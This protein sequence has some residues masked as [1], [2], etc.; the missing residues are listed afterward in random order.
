MPAERRGGGFVGPSFEREADRALHR[1]QEWVQC[2]SQECGEF[3]DAVL[4]RQTGSFVGED[5][6]PLAR[7]ER[8]VKAFR[9]DDR[10]GTEWQYAARVGERIRFRKRKDL[11]AA[12]ELEADRLA[13]AAAIPVERAKRV[14]ADRN[15]AHDGRDAD[16]DWHGHLAR[17]A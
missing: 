14:N 4:V 17:D 3:V 7:I 1:A 6:R 10:P 8:L 2:A 12:L 15:D 11:A 5:G 13:Q 16:R 9:D